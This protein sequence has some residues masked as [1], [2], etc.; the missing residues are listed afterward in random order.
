MI[1]EINLVKVTLKTCGALFIIMALGFWTSVLSTPFCWLACHT[2]YLSK[3]AA[4]QILFVIFL[5]PLIYWIKADVKKI[6]PPVPDT[7][8]QPVFN[9]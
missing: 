1:V 6:D 3:L 9:M 7:K 5:A 4:I 2:Q 8:C